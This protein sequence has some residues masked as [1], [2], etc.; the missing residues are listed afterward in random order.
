MVGDDVAFK[1]AT[2]LSPKWFREHYFHRMARL[3]AA[4]HARG[5]KVMFHSDGN[6]NLILDG[7]VEAGVDGLNPIE[8]LA[9]MD[10]GDIH[11]R[12]P[13]LFMCGGIDVSQ[14]LPLGTP[15]QVSEAVHRAVDAAEG[16]IMIGSSTELN[17]EVPLA[18]Y[19]A[20]REAVLS[21]PY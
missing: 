3:T 14:L 1:T 15:E 20:L 13:R 5:I 19:L 6:L 18:N 9:G 21:H 2:M 16:R 10:V 11:R 12:Y 8:V 4:Y 17:N 7:L